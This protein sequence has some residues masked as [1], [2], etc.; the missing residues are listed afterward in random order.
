MLVWFIVAPSSKCC[1]FCCA[2]GG[3]GY[4]NLFFV[5][6]REGLKEIVVCT[7]TEELAKLL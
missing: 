7:D 2:S 1:F 3:E 6:G 5:V 4:F